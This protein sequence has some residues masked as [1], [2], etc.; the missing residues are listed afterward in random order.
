MKSFPGNCLVIKTGR[1]EHQS[2]KDIWRY[3]KL[4]YFLAWRDILYGF[5]FLLS[6]MIV[7]FSLASGVWYFRKMERTFADVI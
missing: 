6:L 7:A 3:R 1:T 5:V 4:F 2:W